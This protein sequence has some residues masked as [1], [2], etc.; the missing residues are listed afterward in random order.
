MFDIE[1]S[2]ADWR[3]QML[4]AGLKTPVPLEELESHLR[5][6]I[7]RRMQQGLTAQHALEVAV[8]Q[9]GPAN[10][11]TREFKKFNAITKRKQ[12]KRT[13]GIVAALF[14]TVFGGAMVLPA[15][16]RWRD[17]GILHAG[18]LVTG[19]AVAII[20]AC[21]VIYGIR[22]HRGSRGKTVISAFTI[23]AGSFYVTPL[24]QALFIPKVNGTGWIF[25]ILLAAAANSFYGSCLYFIR[26]PPAPAA[27]ER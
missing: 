22:K 1:Q 5:E 19:G 15:L 23:L 24:I 26:H 25:C 8:Q 13:A 17:T 4:A 16:G 9:I 11:L 21:A 20:A 2:I 27:L 12:M 3:Q 6:D 18:P 10:K 7:A 14:G